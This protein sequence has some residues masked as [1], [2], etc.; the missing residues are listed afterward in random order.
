[1]SIRIL[2]PASRYWNAALVLAFLLAACGRPRA[3]FAEDGAGRATMIPEGWPLDES[4]AEDANAAST[5]LNRLPKTGEVGES[6]SGFILTSARVVANQAPARPAPLPEAA[7]INAPPPPTGDMSTKAPSD[8]NSSPNPY[9]PTGAG[10]LEK[11]VYERGKDWW[12]KAGAGV[13]MSYNTVEGKAPK[14]TLGRGRWN[15]DFNLNNVRLYFNGQASKYIGMEVNTDLTNAQW[16]NLPDQPFEQ[17]GVMRILDAIAKFQLSEHLNIWAGRMIVPN[18]RSDLSGPFYINAF[19]FP[20]VWSYPNIFQ[21]RDDGAVAWGQFGGGKLKYYVGIFEGTRNRGN[22]V[23]LRP[24]GPN[25]SDNPE[26]A[27][28]VVWNLLDPEPGYYNQ[29]TYY[30]EK[31]ILAIGAA[32][33]HQHDAVGS[34]ANQRDF[35]GWNIDALF[36]TRLANQGVVTLEGAFYQY[37]DHNA[38]LVDPTGIFTPVARQGR[39][40][41]VLASYLFPGEIAVGNISGKLQPL[42]RYQRYDRD[43][44]TV[45]AL[46]EGHDF[47]LNYIIAGHDAR[48]S[49]VYSRRGAYATHRYD[50]ARVGVQFQF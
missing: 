29:S 50:I 20:F 26:F 16:P 11:P 30:G 31:D 34:A 14:G 49:F 37:N 45:G 25:Q 48:V 41:F 38:A 46:T 7:P 17:G 6:R 22:P 13:K 1:M 33:M 40:G 21:G 15:N 27:A 12:L 8:V 35:T 3:A 9:A 19:E 47:Q 44:P 43:F 18:D 24:F 36:E 4:P 23:A 5:Q 39:S 2:C 28:R 10:W 32:V 42:Y